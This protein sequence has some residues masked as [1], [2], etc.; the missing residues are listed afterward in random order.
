MEDNKLFTL[1]VITPNRIFFEEEVDFVEMVTTEGEIGVY[2]NHIPTT[3]IL[4]PGTLKIH[5]GTTVRKAAVHSGFVIILQ[6]MVRVMAEIAE[7][8][9]EIDINRATEA[10]NRAERRL[11]SPES[12]DNDWKRAEMALKRSLTRINITQK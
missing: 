11:G 1:K 5:K 7:W 4:S 6:D 2:K 9:D 10:K 3:M 12:K 8:P